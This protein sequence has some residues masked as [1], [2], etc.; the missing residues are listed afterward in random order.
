MYEFSH[1]YVKRNYGE[2][3]K[4]CCMDTD[5]FILYI[6]TFANILQKMLKLDSILQI[7]NQNAMLLMDLYLKEKI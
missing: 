2:K 6:K 4:L 7:M 3:L 1:D 5:S